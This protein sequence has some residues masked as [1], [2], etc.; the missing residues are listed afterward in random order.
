VLKITRNDVQVGLL[1]TLDPFLQ[2]QALKNL[3]KQIPR[4]L[5]FISQLID[6][7]VEFQ[8]KSSS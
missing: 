5:N 1:M 3:D 2:G 6:R 4:I 7:F 8:T